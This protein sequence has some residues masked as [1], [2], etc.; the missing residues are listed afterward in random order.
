MFDYFAF[1]GWKNELYYDKKLSLNIHVYEKP[2]K[3]GE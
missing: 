2:M 3:L 1:N